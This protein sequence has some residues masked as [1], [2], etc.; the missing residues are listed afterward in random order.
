MKKIMLPFRGDSIPCS[1]EWTPRLPKSAPYPVLYFGYDCETNTY[2]FKNENE[3]YC[4][5]F[6]YDPWWNEMMDCSPWDTIICPSRNTHSNTNFSDDIPAS[7]MTEAEIWEV[8]SYIARSI[9]P[10]RRRKRCKLP[11]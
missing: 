10:E 11:A 3:D 2:S 5:M 4:I 6:S 8:R 7:I 1:Y 9:M